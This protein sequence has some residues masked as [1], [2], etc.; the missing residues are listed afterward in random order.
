MTA[1]AKNR[2]GPILLL[3][4]IAAAIQASPAAAAPSLSPAG[5]VRYPERGFV[6]TLPQHSRLAPGQVRVSENGGPVRGLRVA[7]LGASRRAKFG[8]VLAI[9]ASSSMRGRA[10]AGA[11][12]AA[13]AFARERHPRQPLAVLTFSN[14]ARLA[15]PFTAQEG[16]IR[17]ALGSPAS[18]GGG[19]HMYDASLRALDLVRRSGLPGGFVVVLSDGTDRGSVATGDDVVAA[20][21]AARARIYTVGL[22]SKHFDP[23][24]LRGLAEAGGGEYS[25]ASSPIELRRIYSALGA[26]L[27]NAHLVSYRSLSGP[28]R[29]IKVRADVAGLGAASASYQSPRLRLEGPAAS[30]GGGWDSPLATFLAVLVVVGL[31]ALSV[32]AVRRS[33]RQT[34]RERVE[35]FVRQGRRGTTEELTL[36]DRLAAGAERSFSKTEWW[37]GF[38]TELDVADVRHSPGHVML[39]AAVAALTLALVVTAAAGSALGGLPCLVLAPLVGWVLLRSRARRERLRFGEQLPDHLAVV[40]GSLRAGHSLQSALASGLEDAPEPARRQFARAVADEQLGMP[41]EDA[42]QALAR[43]MDNREVEHI[44][45][46]AKLQRE[47]GADA[48]EMVD[49]VVATMRERQELRRAVRTLTAQGRLAQVILSILPVAALLLLTVTNRPYVDPLYS[50]SIGHTLL[51]V[52]AALVVAGSLVIRRIVT[53]RI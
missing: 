45:L 35:Q 32:L 21:R 17:H 8:V 3:A 47:A 51:G 53:F 39:G 23:A 4:A 18:T 41:L 27:S 6:L 1:N 10:Y 13:R 2:I 43:R 15:L 14:R 52:S 36:A 25:E 5:D 44:S 26:Q 50:T 11:F 34:P 19:T 20:A 46:L 37:A 40:G 33:R 29:R 48:A 24:A 38:A 9:D 16:R 42:L 22:R 28:G 30:T 31:L 49:Q 7:P 12:D